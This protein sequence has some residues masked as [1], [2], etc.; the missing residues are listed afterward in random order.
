MIFSLFFCIHTFNYIILTTQ[1]FGAFLFFSTTFR[2]G[3]NKPSAKA[4]L[5]YTREKI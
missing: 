3:F 2:P 1:F 4:C 5:N